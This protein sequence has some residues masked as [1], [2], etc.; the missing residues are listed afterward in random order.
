[1]GVGRGLAGF[2]AHMNRKIEYLHA[3]ITWLTSVINHMDGR[4]SH[5][6]PNLGFDG[7][8]LFGEDEFDV[9]VGGELIYPIE[10]E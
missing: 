2:Y 1:M 10:V 4:R 7:E 3:K 5:A 6:H 8:S 9:E